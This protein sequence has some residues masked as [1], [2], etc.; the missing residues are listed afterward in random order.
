MGLVT[1]KHLQMVR[2]TP[3]VRTTTFVSTSTKFMPRFT[4]LGINS[5]EK[6][7][8]YNFCDVFIYNTLFLDPNPFV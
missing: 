8:T 3:E 4:N 1:L 6:S 7:S 2:T 5:H